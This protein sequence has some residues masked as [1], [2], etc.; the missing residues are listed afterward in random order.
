MTERKEIKLLW[1]MLQNRGKW[2]IDPY[3]PDNP[4][5][6][7]I[8]EKAKCYANDKLSN[9]SFRTLYERYKRW[10]KR[11][12]RIIWH[13]KDYFDIFLDDLIMDFG[14]SV[15]KG[16][17]KNIFLESCNLQIRWLR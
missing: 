6:I 12:D 4:L 2:Y 10:G 5:C 14:E 15:L 17:D 7:D 9:I 8:A 16:N 11:S 1:D 3:A 13:E